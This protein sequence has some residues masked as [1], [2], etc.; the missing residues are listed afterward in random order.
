MEQNEN[1]GSDEWLPV[2]LHS[3]AAQTKRQT[4]LFALVLDSRFIPCCIKPA[5]SNWQLLVPPE[6]LD[7]A[8]SELRLYEEKN[9]YWPPPLPVARKLIENTLPTVSVLILL[10]TFHNLALLGLS[11]PGHGIIDLNDIGSAHAEKILDGQWWRLVTALTLHA[12]L[13][14]LLGNLTIGGVFIILICREFGSGLAW[15]LLLG[16]GV[17]G[18]LLNAW[19]QAPGHRSVGASTAVFGAVGLMAAISAVRYHHQL[20]RHWFVPIASG[21]ALLAILGT[22]GKNTD[23]GAH[24][25]GFG[26]GVLL[27]LFTEHYCGKY[28]RPGQLLN[29]LLACVAVGLVLLAW[30][31]ALEFGLQ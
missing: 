21:L 7:S 18:N 10:A 8:V 4:K 14:H 1:I 23:L 16:T 12:D 2:K 31:A 30:W 19:I 9:R 25:F 6:H 29:I 5:G 15:S 17:L 11:I 13:P 3:E 27:G 24:L 28:G 26:C 20:R 22:E